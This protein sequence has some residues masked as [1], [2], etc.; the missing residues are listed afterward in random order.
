MAQSV[1]QQ[2]RRAARRNIA[3]FRQRLRT[4]TDTCERKLLEGLI[5]LERLRAEAAET[6]GRLQH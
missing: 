3:A 4:E 6:L 5:V 2:V 1:E